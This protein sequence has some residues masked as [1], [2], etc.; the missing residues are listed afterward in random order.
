MAMCAPIRDV[1]D[2]VVAAL[3]PLVCLG[4]RTDFFFVFAQRATMHVYAERRSHSLF[5]SRRRIFGLRGELYKIVHFIKRDVCR[6]TVASVRAVVFPGTILTFVVVVPVM[7][8]PILALSSSGRAAQSPTTV[9]VRS[10]M[11]SINPDVR[12]LLRRLLRLF[13]SVSDRARGRWMGRIGRRTR[14]TAD[15]CSLWGSDVQQ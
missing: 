15:L 10:V 8:Y 13:L 14:A 2:R 12:L 5:F 11:T 6:S 9:S 4:A 3:L 7:E 1:S